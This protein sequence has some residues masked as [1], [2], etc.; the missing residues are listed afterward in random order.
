[1][2]H[3]RLGWL[4]GLRAVAVLLVLY[5]HLSRYAFPGVRAVTSE[6]L[7]AGTA[8]VML[9]FLVSG[10]I[11]PASLER[12]GDPRRFWAG[13]FRRL[14]PLYLVVVVAATLIPTNPEMSAES[15]VAHL[16]MLPFLLNADLVTPVLWT[17]SFEMA[18]YLLVSAIHALG[19]RRIDAY[20]G[21]TLA[22]LATITA[23][24]V[25]IGR[26]VTV[27]AVIA[28]I[29]GLAGIC[30]RRRWAVRAGGLALAG[31]TGWLLLTGMDPSH[32]WDGLLIL[33]VMFTGTTIYRAD[34]GQTGWWPVLVTG[35]V[36]AAALLTN[37][38]AEL[39]SLDGFTP[40]YVA[41]SVITLL[42]FA[43]AFALGMLTRRWR[44]PGWLARIG[45]ISYS[46]YLVHYV[47]LQAFGASIHGP[48]GAVLFLIALYGICEL[49]YRFI[50]L[51][52][53]RLGRGRTI[54]LP[55]HR[56][57]AGPATPETITAETGVARPGG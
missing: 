7:H 33:A 40:R 12:H 45:V 10:Y 36:V 16:A 24:L 49:T 9:F 14:W 39:R 6:W 1:M 3:R 55:G 15:A 2:L 32:A 17:L 43:G 44:T 52:G 18:F 29:A 21:V 48:L 50:E 4:D 54:S 30:G 13:R 20:A 26:D 37:W 35:T 22:I 8:G 5:A 38:F 25:S 28:L 23:P 46:L 42:V 47:L 57:G 53:Q 56:R 11:I 51:P 34:T 19:L 27:P 31:L 41:R